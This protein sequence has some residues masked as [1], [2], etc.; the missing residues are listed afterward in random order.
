MPINFLVL[1]DK[2]LAASSVDD[3]L[4]QHGFRCNE[5]ISTKGDFLFSPSYNSLLSLDDTLTSLLKFSVDDVYTVIYQLEEYEQYQDKSSASRSELSSAN[6]AFSENCS[7]DHHGL[8]SPSLN[9][10]AASN[11]M[12]F[13]TLCPQQA[14][15]LPLIKQNFAGVLLF[16]TEPLS[17]NT[18][19]APELLLLLEAVTTKTDDGLEPI[20]LLVFNLG[21][22]DAD[23]SQ[24][25]LRHQ[26]AQDLRASYRQAQLP[27]PAE[28]KASAA[29]ICALFDHSSA[30]TLWDKYRTFNRVMQLVT[31]AAAIC[32]CTPKDKESV[33][34]FLQQD[35]KSSS[36]PLIYTNPQSFL[37]CNISAKMQSFMSTVRMLQQIGAAEFVR[38]DLSAQKKLVHELLRAPLHVTIELDDVNAKDQIFVAP[39]RTQH[40]YIHLESPLPQL[41][42][43]EQARPLTIAL[44][45]NCLL[46]HT[47]FCI[48]PHATLL[49]SLIHKAFPYARIVLLFEKNFYA[50]LDMFSA[51]DLLLESDAASLMDVKEFRLQPNAHGAQS[52]GSTKILFLH[53][54]LLF[55]CLHRKK[56]QR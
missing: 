56:R 38:S 10:V 43:S 52:D 51:N 18:H 23:L 17:S 35:P 33:A 2:S 5:R 53:L 36:R 49:L 30:T 45:V 12:R 41:S 50:W 28:I 13:Y 16:L 26:E 19:F 4:L 34:R 29:R 14:L 22:D 46:P 48:N 32:P 40:R 3:V 54:H 7:H 37:C 8:F 1:T 42:P 15:D 55:H 21:F 39:Q 9:P 24:Y 11:S 20:P 27:I 44:A 31:R 6:V 47:L 25:W